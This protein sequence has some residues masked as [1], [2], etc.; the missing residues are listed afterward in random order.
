MAA[1][2]GTTPRSSSRR[3]STA[4]RARTPTTR[5]A[6]ALGVDTNRALGRAIVDQVDRRRV[7]GWIGAIRDELRRR[8]ALSRLMARD[9]ELPRIV[10][11]KKRLAAHLRRRML[12]GSNTSEEPDREDSSQRQHDGILHRPGAYHEGS[13]LRQ[14]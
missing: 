2:R 12:G 1:E 9:D 14:P 13:P 4:A 7:T 6:T 8:L 3:A 5:P 11:G 10:S